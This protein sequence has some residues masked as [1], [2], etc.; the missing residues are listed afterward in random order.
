MRLMNLY[1][2]FEFDYLVFDYSVGS[3]VGF[4]VLDDC[5]FYEFVWFDDFEIECVFILVSLF[6]VFCI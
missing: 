4:V 6:F 5:N 2:F 3:G 1:G